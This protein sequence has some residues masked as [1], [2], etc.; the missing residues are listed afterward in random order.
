[1]AAVSAEAAFTRSWRVGSYTATLTSPAPAA[2][3]VRGAVIEWRPNVPGRLSPPMAD[4]YRRG[5]DKALAD[6]ARALR[7][8]VGVVEL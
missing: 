4:A 7:I 5:R 2:G 6:M 1:M 8:K 3:Q